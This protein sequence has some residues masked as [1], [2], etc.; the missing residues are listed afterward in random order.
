MPADWYGFKIARALSGRE[1]RKVSNQGIFN[2]GDLSRG[3]D[4]LLRSELSSC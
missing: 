2:G 1:P 4:F 3:S